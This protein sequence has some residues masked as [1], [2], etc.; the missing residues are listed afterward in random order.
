MRVHY[1]YSKE[2][3]QL[4][5]SKMKELL[6]CT[7]RLTADASHERV[8][9]AFR[10]ADNAHYGILRK[11]G[12]E[13]PYIIHP[14]E[15]A[16]IVAKE[17]GF[18]SVTIAAALL[19]DTVEDTD[20][21]LEEI[22]REFGKDI[23][24][25]VD[26][27]TKITN[28]FNPHRSDQI[29][30]F[31]DMIL[32]MS[33]D[34]R[35]AFVKIADR[36]HNLR[37]MVGIRE[38]SLMIKSGESLDVYAPLAYKLGLFNIKKE[39]EDL[40]FK[41]RQPTEYQEL[42]DL[43]DNN[44]EQRNEIFKVMSAP[45]SEM[46]KNNGYEF[47]I[48]P[49]TKS[50]YQ[51]WQIIKNNKITFADIHNFMSVRLIFKNVVYYSE[52]V[53][54]FMIYASISELFNVRGLKDWITEPRSNGFEALIT[55]VMLGSW[56]EVQIMSQR[57]GEIAQTGY[58]ADHE[59]L[60]QKNFD[61]WLRS[62]GKKI[63]NDSLTN[64][65]IME[66]LH[67]EDKE[68]DVFSE[69]GDIISLKKN[70]TVLDFAFYIHK[71][72]G[73][74][75]KYAEVGNKAVRID[76]VLHEG[77][78]VKV[79]TAEDI[80]VEKNWI[81]YAVTAKAK[82]TIRRHF[83]KI[84]KQL[85][86]QGKQLFNNLAADF[87][88]EDNILKRLRIRFNCK[89]TDDFFK[90]MA[91]AEISENTVL[92]Y[93]K[94]RK[95]SLM[96]R[97]I[98]GIFGKSEDDDLIDISDTDLVEFNKKNFI[99]NSADQFEFSS[100]CNALPGDECIAYKQPDSTVIVHKRECKEAI[101]LNTSEGKNTAAVHWQMKNADVFPANIYFEGSDRHSVLI[102]VINVISGH[103]HLN[104]TSLNI[105]SKLNYFSGSIT[106]KAPNKDIV[107]KLLHEVASIKN[108]RKVYRV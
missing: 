79:F 87:P 19:H 24:V 95:A 48:I 22:E 78:R 6:M 106:F 41:Y 12:D 44:S 80:T 8:I 61:R 30:T 73:M 84:Q 37:T 54:A 47:E 46:L 88:L 98:G 7:K 69:T 90:K 39:I 66:I 17:M 4:I 3:R 60:H 42:K 59:N 18:G 70:S 85:V 68:I 97:L 1:A 13:I 74:K 103:L 28:V 93:L 91:A 14:I 20:S 9:R 64:E 76:Y 83:N 51:T 29:E 65:E 101:A 104:M 89:D 96:G 25:I 21:T 99:I 16:T 33:K 45:L 81:A 100:C 86:T 82:T 92:N 32:K 75:F 10:Y 15:V 77:D 107:Q 105:E 11:T 55:D 72:L 62:T 52:K 102:D 26:G 56:V 36:L 67:P 23:A 71:D 43:A 38:N 94:K 63:N 40:S 57:M 31:R 35:I 108:I 34:R 27:V 5:D 2:Q 58:A 53:Q 50:L 49:V